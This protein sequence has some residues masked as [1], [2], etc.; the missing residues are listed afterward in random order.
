MK[1]WQWLTGFVNGPVRYTGDRL[2][3][4]IMDAFVPFEDTTRTLFLAQVAD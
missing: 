4:M 1:L 3:S 2:A